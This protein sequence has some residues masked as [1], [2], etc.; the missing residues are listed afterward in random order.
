[1]EQMHCFN[2]FSLYFRVEKEISYLGFA[3]NVGAMTFWLHSSKHRLVHLVVVER[4]VDTGYPD[5]TTCI[6]QLL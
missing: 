3:C 1:M 6:F 2:E 4:L 5:G